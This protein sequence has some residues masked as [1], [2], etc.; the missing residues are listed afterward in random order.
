MSVGEVQL[1]TAEEY[2]AARSAASYLKSSYGSVYKVN[3]IGYVVTVVR[4]S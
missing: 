1:F 2:N 3:K 4:I